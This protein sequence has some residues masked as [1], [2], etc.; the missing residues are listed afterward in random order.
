MGTCGSVKFNSNKSGN[1]KVEE[2][3]GIQNY[4]TLN[5]NGLS[6]IKPLTELDTY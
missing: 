3:N 2:T 4:H 1:T 6:D 5:S